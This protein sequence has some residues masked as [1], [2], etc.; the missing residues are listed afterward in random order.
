MTLTVFDFYS[1]FIEKLSA[2]EKNIN[3][4]ASGARPR[5]VDYYYLGVVNDVIR[6]SGKNLN[7]YHLEAYAKT[8]KF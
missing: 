6:F 4:I 8:N 3:N 5:I 7:R 2:R 1:S